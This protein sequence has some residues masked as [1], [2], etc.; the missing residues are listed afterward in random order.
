MFFR[1]SGRLFQSLGAALLKALVSD[2]FLLV[3]STAGRLFK[4]RL[5]R[6]TQPTVVMAHKLE[7]SPV[8]IG[9]VVF[10][11]WRVKFLNYSQFG[12]CL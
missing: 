10:L 3:S 7:Q 5:G 11:A 4:A 6:R 12:E 8:D 1:F 9:P 2:R